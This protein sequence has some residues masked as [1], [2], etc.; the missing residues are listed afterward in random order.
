MRT[1]ALKGADIIA[2]PSNLILPY[3]PDAM[4]TRCLENR[5]FA[6]TA[7][8]TGFEQRF[9][10]ER[11][12]F[13]GTSQITS[14]GGERLYRAAQYQE[15]RTCIEIVIEKARDKNLNPFNNPFN[16]IFDDRRE[17]FYYQK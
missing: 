17:K 7:N 12:K 9:D 11:L 2:Y 3:C 15:E 8:R 14:P 13:I 6:V 10:K 16:N 5:V 1:L 4:V